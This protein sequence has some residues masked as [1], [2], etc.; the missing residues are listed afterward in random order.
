MQ[1][2]RVIGHYKGITPVHSADF[3]TKL[4][5]QPNQSSKSTQGL[6]V[7]VKTHRG[8]RAGRTGKKVPVAIFTPSKPGFAQF[9]KEHS[10]PKH[11]RVTAGGRIV[12]MPPMENGIH[13]RRRSEGPRDEQT[14]S[15]APALA[16][17]GVITRRSMGEWQPLPVTETGIPQMVAVAVLEPTNI[18]SDQTPRAPA[19]QP[20]RSMVPLSASIWHNIRGG[21]Q[22]TGA[23]AVGRD[24]HQRVP[25]PLGPQSNGQRV[26]EGL[27]MDVNRNR[28]ESATQE[29]GV[30]TTHGFVMPVARQNGIVTH[31]AEPSA[32]Q[33][34]TTGQQNAML[35]GQN[36]QNGYRSTGMRNGQSSNRGAEASTTRQNGMHTI[37]RAWPSIR[38]QNGI[39]SEHIEDAEQSPQQATNRQN[40]WRTIRTAEATPLQ[41]NGV[42]NGDIEDAEQSAE[43]TVIQQN[44]RGMHHRHESPT[45]QPRRTSFSRTQEVSAALQARLGVT[46]RDETSSGQQNGTVV[47]GRAETSG[48]QQ[49]DLGVNQGTPRLT[50]QSD[51]G[52]TRQMN[53]SSQAGRQSFGLNPTA[54]SF[55][56]GASTHE[57]VLVTN[58]TSVPKRV[59]G[60][61]FTTPRLQ[62]REPKSPWSTPP[63]SKQ[64]IPAPQVIDNGAQ[65]SSLADRERA[66]NE[67]DL[68]VFL[69]TLS[70]V[71]SVVTLGTEMQVDEYVNRLHV[72]LL[73]VIMSSAEDPFRTRLRRDL[74]Q[75]LT[76]QQERLSRALENVNRDIALMELEPPGQQ[77]PELR[78]RM[79]ARRVYWTRIRGMTVNAIDSL[80]EIIRQRAYLNSAEVGR[81]SF[82]HTTDAATAVHNPAVHQQT[83]TDGTNRHVPFDPEMRI[84]SHHLEYE[85]TSSDESGE[86]NERENLLSSSQYNVQAHGDRRVRSEEETSSEEASG[87]QTSRVGHST[88]QD[89]S[90]RAAQ[91]GWRIHRVPLTSNTDVSFPESIQRRNRMATPSNEMVE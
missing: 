31:R 9:L 38:Q 11:Q 82:Q 75:E 16:V 53:Q 71:A 83:D 13:N 44:G 76:R 23:N 51:G 64:Q 90:S 21:V 32:V 48:P 59:L 70:E 43:R 77:D 6:A 8:R 20:P 54:Q 19:V 10:S 81:R 36:G 35:N 88:D 60:S 67:R 22:Y 30:G 39:S 28:Q 7:K 14:T 85:T 86:A 52:D 45:A 15:H 18:T 27:R 73:L 58:E 37:R 78:Q 46:R 84:A 12:P 63:P 62:N 72:L 49:V 5:E 33:Q 3:T 42:S 69:R 80:E 4:T 1:S 50:A 91:E 40:G 61:P 89:D 55:R 65:A 17:N 47:S 29:S 74:H 87:S 56:V 66:I 34:S 57:V 41:Q 2:G 26:F 25:L 24:M 68:D 79:I